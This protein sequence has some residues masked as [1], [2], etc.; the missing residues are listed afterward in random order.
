M[1]LSYFIISVIKFICIRI[2][3]SQIRIF[4]FML[5]VKWRQTLPM[6]GRECT[7]I[8]AGV[9]SYIYRAEAQLQSVRFPAASLMLVVIALVFVMFVCLI[10]LLKKPCIYLSST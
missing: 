9:V 3:A 7:C 1:I 8:L 4:M 10:N 5:G 6:F 2:V